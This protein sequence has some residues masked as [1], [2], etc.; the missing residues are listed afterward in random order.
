MAL[1]AQKRSSK[2]ASGTGILPV[3]T[4]DTWTG[5][6]GKGDAWGRVVGEGLSLGVQS[7]K[8]KML[9]CGQSPHLVR[10]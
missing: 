4:G 10:K 7:A 8:R 5:K 9:D 1:C 3:K 6:Q 2:W